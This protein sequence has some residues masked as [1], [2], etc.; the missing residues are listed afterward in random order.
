[1]LVPLPIGL[2]ACTF[3][4]D[5][6]Y[7][8]SGKED[9]WYDFAFWTGLAAIGAALLAALPG[10]GDYLTMRMSNNQRT[11]ATA[12]MLLN[13]SIVGIFAAAFVLSL[14]H[15]ATDGTE[16]EIV[17]ALHAIGLGILG[18]SGWL[19]GEMVYVQHMAIAETAGRAEETRQAHQSGR[20]QTRPR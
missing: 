9:M 17:V 7:L 3:A 11:L 4:S 16:L 13:L 6:I 8:F 1:M 12:H 2:I 15:N 10:F 18:V 19:G 14:D 20:P 5:L